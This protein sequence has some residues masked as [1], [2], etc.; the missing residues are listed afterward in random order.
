MTEDRV[1]LH[2]RPYV[3]R[4]RHQDLV[5]ALLAAQLGC[6]RDELVLARTSRG[7]PYVQAPAGPGLRFSLT[8]CPGLLAV[9]VGGPR[10]LGVDAEP[11][12][13]QPDPDAFGRF[14]TLDERREAARCGAEALVPWWVRKEAVLK[15]VGAGLWAD[16]R[17]WPVPVGGNGRLH[18]AV[19]RSG[20]VHRVRDLRYGP[21][22]LAVACAGPANFSVQM[23]DR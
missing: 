3:P 16:P 17:D 20:A 21:Y 18:F 1:V 14:M 2:L 5:R 13:Q 9:A 6:S 8:H 23:R 19:G 11:A 10:E 12:A 7:K 15:A 4:R 22:V